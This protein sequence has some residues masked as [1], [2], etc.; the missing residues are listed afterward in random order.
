MRPDEAQGGS[1]QPEVPAARSK[2]WLRA[3]AAGALALTLGLGQAW[4]YPP[5]GAHEGGQSSDKAHAFATASAQASDGA[6]KGASPARPDT[7]AQS[8]AQ[9]GTTAPEP[10]F[11][12]GVAKP[13]PKSKVSVDIDEAGIGTDDW[14]RTVTR[15]VT[16]GQLVSSTTRSTSIAIDD[17]GNQVVSV[18]VAR[19]RA[20][21]NVAA[22]QAGAGSIHTNTSV[23]VTGNGTGSA[24]AGGSIGVSHGS[25]DVSTWGE[26]SAEVF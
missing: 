2:A 13:T 6:A 1:V 17:A 26:T 7:A 8:E 19:A 24:S 4:A 22:V 3:I 10:R 16:N 18:A 9:A 5:T 25:V 12:F 23:D 15:T 20:P 14:T 11:N 21:N